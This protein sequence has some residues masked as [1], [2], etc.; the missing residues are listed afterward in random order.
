MPTPKRPRDA[1]EPHAPGSSAS[2]DLSFVHR[3]LVAEGWPPD[4]AAWLAPTLLT[5]LSPSAT[6]TPSPD[7]LEQ[8]LDQL[9]PFWRT[10]NGD[11]NRALLAMLGWLTGSV[12]PGRIVGSDAV[13]G[14]WQPSPAEQEQLA[15]RF[16]ASGLDCEA[17]LREGWPKQLLEAW[18]RQ[19]DGDDAPGFAAFRR[20]LLSIRA[21]R[22]EC[23]VDLDSLRRSGAS[24]DWTPCQTLEITDG[25]VRWGDGV[26]WQTPTALRSWAWYEGPAALG[27][28]LPRFQ[29]TP[30]DELPA[31]AVGIVREVLAGFGNRGST[32]D[33]HHHSE[34]HRAD[35]RLRA[36]ILPF[37]SHVH[38]LTRKTERRDS[39]AL[40]RTRLLLYRLAFD[41]APEQC[42]PETKREVLAAATEDLARLRNVFAEARDDARDQAAQSFSDER[43]HFDNCCFALARHGGIWRCWKPLLLAMRKLATPCVADDLRYWAEPGL[44]PAPTPWNHLPTMIVAVVHACAARDPQQDPSLRGLREQIAGFCLERLKDRWTPDQRRHADT[45]RRQRADQDMVEPVAAWRYCLVRAVGDL[46]VNPEGRGHRTLH[47]S[48]QHDPDADVREA[49]RHGYQSMR[50]AGDLP[51]HVSPRRAVIRAFW[52]MRQAHLLG[53]GIQPDRDLAQRTRE[54]ELTRTK[55]FE[56]AAPPTPQ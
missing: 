40:R 11:R 18:G 14:G 55:E 54:K 34:F 21:V 37:F 4:D 10:E 25:A 2:H 52:W 30:D 24:G 23:V 48:L 44:P 46:Q 12:S 43:L 5:A 13:D 15:H 20:L 51:K 41:G 31:L 22:L 33:W 53:L 36:A 35:Y 49:A 56:R 16:L 17:V 28:L 29:A 6:S 3:R 45:A 42:P 19:F 50:H 39:S 38:E 9:A 32:L 8:R 47:W 26:S 1:V 7:R 27:R